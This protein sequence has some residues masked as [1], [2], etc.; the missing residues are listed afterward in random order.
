MLLNSLYA[1]DRNEAISLLKR[2]YVAFGT[3]LDEVAA[4]YPP[5][6]INLDGAASEQ[7]PLL[8]TA[9]GLRENGFAFCRGYFRDTA[10]LEACRDYARQVKERADLLNVQRDDVMD[11]E[12][13]G[14]LWKRLMAG[15]NSRISHSVED[16][17]QFFRPMIEDSFF[18]EVI[19]LAS[20]SRRPVTPA[21]LVV[22]HL[23]PNTEHDFLWWHFDRLADQFKVMI[24]LDDVDEETG[25]MKLIPKTHVHDG[26]SRILDF[27]L[28]AGGGQ[29]GGEV[30]FDLVS[31][32]F[33][34]MV[35]C[36]GRAGDILFFNTKIFHCHGRPDAKVRLTSTIYFSHPITPLNIFLENFRPPGQV[37]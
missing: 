15:H 35:L 10:M 18:R 2:D 21:L 25:P 17:P 20:G 24:L 33:D 23:Q 28:Y 37:L 19:G 13:R 9:Q 22:D 3:A 32:Q 8:Q 36:T 34:K 7:L 1:M 12:Y 11:T 4:G 14:L 31:R 29:Y 26:Q 30:G 27:T 16:Y 6:P 5:P